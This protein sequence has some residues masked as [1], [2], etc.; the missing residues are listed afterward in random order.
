MRAPG[1][2]NLDTRVEPSILRVATH[3]PRVERVPSADP[4]TSCGAG[5]I[6]RPLHLVWS[7]YHLPTPTPRVERVP[8][9]DPYTSCGADTICRPLY[10]VWSGYHLPTT[11]T[12]ASRSRR[13]RLSSRSVRLP[14][15][16]DGGGDY[17]PLHPVEPAALTPPMPQPRT[18]TVTRGG[19]QW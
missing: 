6:C 9:A 14:K 12:Q 5:T 19:R 18:P 17:P 2:E 8:S 4:Y 1:D 13:R 11:A 7:G 15:S 10:L 3:I 16:L